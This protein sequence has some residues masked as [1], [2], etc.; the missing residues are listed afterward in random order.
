MKKSSYVF[1][2]DGDNGFKVELIYEE[3][4]RKC[5]VF[6]PTSHEAILETFFIEK[7]KVA[8]MR[9]SFATKATIQFGNSEF[10]VFELVS[11]LNEIKSKIYS[12]GIA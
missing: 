5:L 10:N 6:S 9:R 8:E 11:L 3:S 4:D 7:D 12:Y 2:D 1:Y